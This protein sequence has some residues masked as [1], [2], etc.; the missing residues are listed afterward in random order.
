MRALIAATIL[1]F[2]PT[3]LL[4]Q[5]KCQ[6]FTAGTNEDRIVDSFDAG[7]NGPSVG[8]TGTGERALLSADGN[9][10]GRSRWIISS[11]GSGKGGV[12]SHYE[13]RAY[14]MY[15]NGMISY[16]SLVGNPQATLLEDGKAVP[17]DATGIIVGGTGAFQNARGTVTVLRTDDSHILE[18]K[19]DIYC[20]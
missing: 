9:V 16:V 11:L 14:H 10:V 4:A 1:A 12:P 18:F 19:Y 6:S 8:D 2:S 13:V 20:D 17:S 3:V 15:D 5:E 7:N